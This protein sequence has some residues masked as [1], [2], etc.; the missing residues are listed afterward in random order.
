MPVSETR[1]G[2]GPLCSAE[3]SSGRSSAPSLWRAEHTRNTPDYKLNFAALIPGSVGLTVPE[4]P[5]RG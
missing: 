5:G 1:R 3:S 4:G 2:C